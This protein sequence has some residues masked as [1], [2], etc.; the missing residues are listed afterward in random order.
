MARGILRSV[1]VLALARASSNTDSCSVSVSPAYPIPY[2]VCQDGNY[3]AEGSSGGRVR[4]P[5]WRGG[6][7]QLRADTQPKKPALA[8]DQFDC[9][10]F[11]SQAEAQAELTRNPSD[12]S[13][14]DGPV[15]APTATWSSPLV[16]KRARPLLCSGTL[17]ASRE[18]PSLPLAPNMDK[19][20]TPSSSVPNA[21]RTLP[22]LSTISNRLVRTTSAGG[23]FSDS[24]NACSSIHVNLND[25]QLMIRYRLRLVGSGTA[26]RSVFVFAGRRADIV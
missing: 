9:A 26:N 14:I 15:L 10:S 16:S 13:G 6:G 11:D 7:R 22:S 25:C 2:N 20:A 5:R 21:A 8:Q 18:T 1:P 24:L 17:L 12:P 23:L 19:L 3:T 4:A